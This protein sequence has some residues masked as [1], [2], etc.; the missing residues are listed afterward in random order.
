MGQRVVVW[1][2]ATSE[3][4]PWPGWTPGPISIWSGC[5]CRARPRPAATP[6]TWPVW[7]GAGVTATHDVETILALQPDC[8]V[9]TAMADNR[10]ME[11]L[12][13]IAHLLAAG[14]NVVSSGPVFLQYPEGSSPTR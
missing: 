10:I 6:G 7:A 3:G 2:R 11:A 1:E 12:D 5:G 9:H 4:T 8:I 13:D 14:I